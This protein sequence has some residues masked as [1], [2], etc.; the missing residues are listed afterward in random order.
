MADNAPPINLPRK[1]LASK[2]PVTDPGYRKEAGSTITDLERSY[3]NTSIKDV[4]L[5]DKTQAIRILTR[6][7]GTFSA[8]LNAYLQ[9]G[10]SSGYRVTAYQVGSHQF[11]PGGTLAAQSV[12]AALDTLYDYTAGFSSKQSVD[13]LLE[14][15]VKEVL[16][17]GACMCELVLNKF[18]LPEQIVTIPINTIEWAAKADGGRF[19]RQIPSSGDKISLD[20]PTIFYAA[21]AQQSNSIFPRSPLESALNMLYMYQELLEDIFRVIRRTGHTRM[22][23]KIV[24]ESVMKMADPDTL[25]DAT[26]LAAFFDTTRKQIETLLAD[27]N[28][29]DAVVMYDSAEI[30]SISSAGDKAD[31]ASMLDTLS[32][33]LASALKTMPSVLGMRIGG[34]Q[35]LSN[36]ESLVFL[37]MVEGLRRPVETVMSRAITLAVRLV[38]GTD[39]YVKFQFKPVDLRPESEL[40]AHRSVDFQNIMRKLSAGYLTDDEAA[41]LTGT[42]PRAPGAPNRSGTG[43]M[44]KTD[45]TQPKDMVT[46]KDG[47]QAKNLNEG[48][49]NGSATSNGG[50]NP[51]G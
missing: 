51:N 47:A 1:V 25:A 40:S 34:S 48:T 33:M 44:D 21:H 9:L 16:Q 39:S 11:D 50:G 23:V 38:A 30:D 19:P 45:S 35:S 36:T 29:E 46:D 8:A 3:L 6:T 41:H 22:V 2:V 7:D 13:A 26:K 10:M 49:A 12:L 20:L 32:G 27:L 5:L 37:K 43:F 42:F 18:R 4:R 31:Y 15:M 17:T 28:P 14:T 24:Q